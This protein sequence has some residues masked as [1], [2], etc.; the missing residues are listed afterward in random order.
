MNNLVPSDVFVSMSNH[1]IAELTGKSVSNVN[2]DILSMLQ[3][4]REKDHSNYN[5]DPIQG[6]TINKDERGYISLILLDHDH[7]VCLITGYSAVSRMRVIRR[8]K[9]LEARPPTPMYLL[10]EEKASR[11]FK[12]LQAIAV[13]TGLD[14]NESCLRANIAVRNDYG[15]IL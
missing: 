11:G 13:L 8:L 15:V 10:A 7:T 2:Q 14:H 9:D 6:V 4:L 5:D 12:A 3:D 1:E